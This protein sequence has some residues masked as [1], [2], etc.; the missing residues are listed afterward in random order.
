MA[1]GWETVRLTPDGP[2]ILPIGLGTW[3]WGD[4]LVWGYGRR[5]RND[6]LQAALRAA[7]DGGVTLF[8]TAEIYGWGRSERLLGQFNRANGG[9]AVSGPERIAWQGSCWRL[10]STATICGQGGADGDDQ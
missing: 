7:V 4:R 9:P 10:P 3:Q 8:D 2:P 5:Y 6:Y 1:S